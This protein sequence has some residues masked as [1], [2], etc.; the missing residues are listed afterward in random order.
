MGGGEKQN[1]VNQNENFLDWMRS[2]ATHQAAGGIT[3]DVF[4]N[5]IH[6]FSKFI[7][8]GSSLK[9]GTWALAIGLN[10]ARSLNCG[11]LE[12]KSDSLTAVNLLK[13]DL[14]VDSHH[15]SALILYCRSI[16]SGFSYF[17]VKHKHRGG[18]FCADKLV[19][20]VVLSSSPF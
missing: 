16:L 6:G 20:Q 7:G 18:N 3:R 13:D 19:K 12:I 8:N 17:Q 1:L 2:N 4:G 15:L 9:A 10:L 5:W 14:N 11:K